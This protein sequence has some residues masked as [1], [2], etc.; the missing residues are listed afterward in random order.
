M[1]QIGGILTG[2]W[3]K[4][5]SSNWLILAHGKDEKAAIG[6]VDRVYTVKYVLRDRS[7]DHAFR[8]ARLPLFYSPLTGLF[9]YHCTT[10]REVSLSTSICV[11]IIFCRI[12]CGEDSKSRKSFVRISLTSKVARSGDFHILCSGVLHLRSFL[13]VPQTAKSKLPRR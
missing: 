6:R 7:R 11:G 4:I 10:C 3:D 12:L 5:H 13:R 8:Y 1:A 2:F 9:A